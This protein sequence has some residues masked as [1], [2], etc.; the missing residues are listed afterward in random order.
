MKR[1]MSERSPSGSSGASSRTSLVLSAASD[2]TT[3][4]DEARWRRRSPPASARG[5]R[6]WR[7]YSAVRT[8]RDRSAVR[9]SG[10]RTVR[11]WRASACQNR[12]ADPPHGVGDELHALIGIELPGRGE[13]AH[14]ALADQI[15]ER[16]SAVLVFLGDG[17]DEAQVAL[18]QLLHRLLIAGPDQFRN[19]DFL[20]RGEQWSQAHLVEVLI[21]DVPIG[22]IDAQGLRGFP[23]T[24]AAL[25]GG[26]LAR[27]FWTS[28]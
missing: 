18:H 3:S 19:G 9:L 27:I 10:T 6:S 23:F 14:V 13:Q 1:S 12:L 8:M 26:E 20:R 25:L 15:G 22:V 5:A 2:C 28:D 24:A 11:P 21:E 17:D 4:S 16:Q 7:R